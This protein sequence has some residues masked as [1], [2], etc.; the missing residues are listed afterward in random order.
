M[1][2]DGS[3]VYSLPFPP[4]VTA[5]AIASTVYNGFTNDVATDLNAVRP[6]IAGGSGANSADQAL[7][8]FSGE[9][10]SAVVTNYDT[11]IWQP[12]S[13]YSASGA[14]NPPVSGHAF[15][16]IAYSSDTPAYP[17]ANQN[18]VVEARDA[19]D[20]KVYFRR[21]TAGVWGAWTL[22]A[23]MNY[24]FKAGDVMTGNLTLTSLDPAIGIN[25][26]TVGHANSINGYINTSPRWVMQLGDGTNESGGNVGSD[27][28]LYRYADNGT[29]IGRA[30]T[31]S[32]ANGSP[33]FSSTI[34]APGYAC[35]T[36]LSGV[37]SGNIFNLNYTGGGVD[38]WIDTSNLGRITTT[39]DYRIKKNV[40]NLPGMWDTVKKL[41]PIKY[42]QAEFTPPADVETSKTRN[43]GPMFPADNIERWG[44]IAHELQETLLESA[45]TGVKDSPDHIQ[46]PNPFTIIAALTKALQEAMTRIEAL[47]AR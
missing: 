10:S 47:E 31:I 32:R 38:L 12:G 21:K 41:R 17:P 11:Q 1:P 44:F 15:S 35:R 34:T 23:S 6:I 25:T 5:T 43:A 20:N 39:S 29:Q 46:S 4:V 22:D 24:V 3:G 36:G 26:T 18:V 14:T 2:R 9:K 33:T 40:L 13:F 30:L 45:A 8:N 42:T 7:F 16:G 19:T 27:F 37:Y 28:A